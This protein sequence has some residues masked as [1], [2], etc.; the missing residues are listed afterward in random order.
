MK[1]NL[2]MFY[3]EPYRLFFPLG[4]IMLLWGA[5]LWVPQM[6]SQESYPVVAHRYLMINGFCSLFIAG[7]LMTAVPKFSNTQSAHPLEVGAFSFVTFLGLFFSFNNQEALSYLA[8]GFSGVVLL[9]FFLRR[10]ITKKV[11]PPYSFIFIFIGLIFWILSSVMCAFQPLDT[12]KNLH[13]QGAILAIILG[14]GSRLLPGILGHVEI[15][16]SQRKLY[17]TEKAYLKTIPFWFFILI[18][19]FILSYFFNNFFGL[20]L[21]FLT[22]FS[23][24]LSYWKLYKAPAEKTA[25]T[26][27]LWF[28]CWL[29]VISFFISLIWPGGGIHAS[30]SF[31]LGGIVLLSLLIATRVLQSH[32]IKEK[33]VES[34]KVLYVI[35]FLIFLAGATRVSAILMPEHY[36][37]HLGYSS[38]TLVLA[39]LIWSGFYLRYVGIKKD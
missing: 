20:L 31:F 8:S 3:K 4:V 32:G 30:H 26:W 11:N 12:Y 5:L 9:L 37:H 14:V 27:S 16:Q 18:F 15:V 23:I 19:L 36:L 24:A 39:V 7:F 2:S 17:E 29:I 33:K 21:R 22:V 6:W 13:S 28:S 38:I 1:N 10:L 25:L 34:Y 35:S